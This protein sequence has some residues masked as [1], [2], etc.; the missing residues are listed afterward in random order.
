MGDEPDLSLSKCSPE[1]YGHY[2]RWYDMEEGPEKQL[3]GPLTPSFSSLD[4]PAR[5][6]RVQYLHFHT[7]RAVHDEEKKL[8]MRRLLQPPPVSNW[9][10]RYPLVPESHPWNSLGFSV[11]ERYAC[12]EKA[13]I[14]LVFRL[15]NREN[16]IK[17]LCRIIIDFFNPYTSKNIVRAGL[18]AE[19][20]KLNDELARVVNK[21][22][23]QEFR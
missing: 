10:E 12:W 1:E 2:I 9:A 18:R 3:M 15:M 19:K 8:R 22:Q 6:R 4:S 20:K 5:F 21:R 16:V 23:I 11:R 7:W 13:C 14:F 17:P